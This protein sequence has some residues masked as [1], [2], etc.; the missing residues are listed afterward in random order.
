MWRHARPN[1][2]C[3]L[4]QREDVDTVQRG[5]HW[6]GGELET[7]G[8]TALPP[9]PLPPPLTIYSRPLWTSISSLVKCDCWIRISLETVALNYD[10]LKEYSTFS[11]FS[12][13]TCTPVLRIAIPSDGQTIAHGTNLAYCLFLYLLWAKK[14]FYIFKNLFCIYILCER[15]HLWPTKC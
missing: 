9:Y 12:F 8:H 14:S 10:C 6:A 7:V 4:H 1:S 3:D 13:L 2:S 11:G 15:D 5:Q